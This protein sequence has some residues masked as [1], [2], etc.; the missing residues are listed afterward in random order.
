LLAMCASQN[1]CWCDSLSLGPFTSTS[2]ADMSEGRHSSRS[3]R[4]PAHTQS[5]H[6]HLYHVDK[7]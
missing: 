5:G 6:L 3:G 7:V 1:L 4:P 2:F